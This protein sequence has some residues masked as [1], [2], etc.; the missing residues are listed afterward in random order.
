[1][2]SFSRFRDDFRVKIVRW[3]K[4]FAPIAYEKKAYFSHMFLRTFM[5]SEGIVFT[6]IVAKIVDYIS[7]RNM[8]G[9]IFMIC[10][11]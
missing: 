11:F 4:L 2:S 3:K 7:T 1:M 8:Q 5:A 6:W 10:F 9:I